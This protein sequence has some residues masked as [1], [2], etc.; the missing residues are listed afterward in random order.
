MRQSLVATLVL[1]AATLALYLAS[2]FFPAIYARDW[3]SSQRYLTGLE[4][5]AMGCMGLLVGS[6]AWYANLCYLIG[7]ILLAVRAKG[8]AAR[9]LFIVALVLGLQSCMLDQVYYTEAKASPVTGL[10]PAFY[11]WWVAFLV[12][13]VGAELLARGAASKVTDA[14]SGQPGG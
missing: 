2:L 8:R 5:L 6:I 11:L 9:N 7:L 3:A 14:G 12:A 1:L 4:V 10:G 13:A